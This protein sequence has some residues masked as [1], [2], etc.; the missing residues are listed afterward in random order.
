MRNTF[1]YKRQIR[2]NPKITNA[3]VNADFTAQ[4]AAAKT[5]MEVAARNKRQAKVTA[6]LKIEEAIMMLVI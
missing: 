3:L 2:T 6:T 4:V 5:Q 1:L